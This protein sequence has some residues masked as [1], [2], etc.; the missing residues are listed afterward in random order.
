[1]AMVVK[2]NLSALR[3][4]TALNKNSSALQKSLEKVSSGQKIVTAKDDSSAYV[5]SEKMREQIRTLSQDR[6]NVQNGASLF[7]IAEGGI[8]S[9]VEELRNLKELAI[10]AAND[11][12]TDQDRATIQKEFTQKMANINDIATT[13]NY[14][15]KTLLDGTYSTGKAEDST[16]VNEPSG[17]AEFSV[18]NNGDVT[19]TSDGVYTIQSGF[20]GTINVNAKNVKI[21]QEDS[22]TALSNV[23]I[24][25]ASGGNANLW[26]ENLNVTNTE[27]KNIIKFGSGG[28]NNLTVKG[29]NELC[30]LGGYSNSK[31]VINIGGGLTIEGDGTLTARR[32]TYSTEGAGIGSDAYE[33]ISSSNIVIKGDVTINS[34]LSNGAGIGSGWNGEVGNIVIYGGATVNI[35]ST[36]G[37]GAGIGS[38]AANGNCG[39]IIICSGANVTA[40]SSYGAGI[41]SGGYGGKAG[42]IAIYSGA[43]VNAVSSSGAGIGSGYLSGKVGDITIYSGADV[44]AVSSSGAGIGTGNTWNNTSLGSAGNITI[45][46]EGENKPLGTLN[47]PCAFV[48]YS[49]SLSLTVTITFLK[50]C[51]L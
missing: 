35:S 47:I 13:T 20:S 4:L 12:N 30:M 38:G 32:D 14:N 34:Q 44:T 48:L 27:N 10:N 37:Q 33:L 50:G 25:G 39:D 15:G 36:G 49:C 9:I 8:N 6:Y 45:Y 2:N 43:N 3:T 26:I 21:T 5:I 17:I 23:S 22:S 1:M 46:S 19:I 24:I 11:T 16:S 29:T 18:D 51:P 40:F 31:A 7:K 28:E 42:N 41:G